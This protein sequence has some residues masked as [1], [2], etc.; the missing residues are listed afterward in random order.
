MHQEN[1][2]NFFYWMIGFIV[3]TRFLVP[4]ICNF[5]PFSPQSPHCW[6]I[7]DL[8][9]SSKASV[10]LAAI[11]GHRVPGLRPTQATKLGSNP[12]KVAKLEATKSQF[13]LTTQKALLCRNIFASCYWE[14][15]CH[16]SVRWLEVIFRWD[17]LALTSPVF[18]SRDQLP[19]PTS[20][21]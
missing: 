17:E 2:F 9:G 4:D 21:R 5:V 20:E 14:V 10:G 13:C 12:G 7:W 18:P 8:R 3:W 16:Q 6:Q 19:F 15:F 1:G 11:A